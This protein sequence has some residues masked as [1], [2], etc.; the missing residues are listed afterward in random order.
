VY[1]LVWGGE[2]SIS[3][4]LRRTAQNSSQV[5]LG[6]SSIKRQPN[7]CGTHPTVIRVQYQNCPWSHRLVFRY[8]EVLMAE[9]LINRAFEQCDGYFCGPS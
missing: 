2:E 7:W 6:G 1:E 5:V 3:R 4:R 8:G 9:V